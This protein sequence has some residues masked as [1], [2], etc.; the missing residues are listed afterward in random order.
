MKVFGVWLAVIL[1]LAAGCAG[2]REDKGLAMRRIEPPTF[3]NGDLAALF[4]Q[5][6]FTARAELS[7][8]GTTTIGDLTA[9]NGSLFLRAGEVLALWDASQQK[10]FLLNDPLQAYAPMRQTTN[11]TVVLATEAGL[12]T[13]IQ[14]SNFDESPSGCGERRGFWNSGWIQN[15]SD[16]GSNVGRIGHASA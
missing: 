13:K 4:G 3:L 15:V 1:G 5:K 14:H 7:S 8:R 10:A 16:D 9:R 6:T 12:P 2:D 11:E